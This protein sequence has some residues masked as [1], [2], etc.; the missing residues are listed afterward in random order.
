M[1]K[2]TYYHLTTHEKLSS[3]LKDGLVPQIGVNSLLAGE[4]VPRIY[5][6]GETDILYWKTIFN[7]DILLK[8]TLDRKLERNDY[9]TYGEFL[10]DE[11]IHPDMIEI[12]DCPKVS[13]R[14]KREFAKQELDILLSVFS[15]WAEWCI[16]HRDDRLNYLCQIIP[17]YTVQMSQTDFSTLSRDEIRDYLIEQSER[18]FTTFTDLNESADLWCPIWETLDMFP[19]IKGHQER[20][21]FKTI[22]VK[23]LGDVVEGLDTGTV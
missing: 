13:T 7:R 21:A 9:D 6:C 11:P 23:K 14:F 10:C 22:F 8:V 3:I 20:I 5:L 1:S 16:N 18:G 2:Y 15:E 4:N 19:D 12:V 17:F